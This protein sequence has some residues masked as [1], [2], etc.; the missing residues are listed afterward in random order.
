MAPFAQEVE[1][2]LGR[3]AGASCQRVAHNFR[4]PLPNSTPQQNAPP[5]PGSGADWHLHA[6]RPTAPADFRPRWFRRGQS[7]G[8][9]PALRPAAPGPGRSL[10]ARVKAVITREITK[11]SNPRTDSQQGSF[12]SKAG[13]A[14][15][16]AE[17]KASRRFRNN[18]RIPIS[19]LHYTER[20]VPI[21]FTLNTALTS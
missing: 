12:L 3:G 14:R 15:H 4:S 16:F 20:E 6:G 2:G 17:T 5:P 19:S 1:S 7:A 13:F 8:C 18:R 10:S 11:A 21:R 9:K